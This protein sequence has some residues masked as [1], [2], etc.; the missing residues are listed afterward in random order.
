MLKQLKYK[1]PG[2]TTHATGSRSCTEPGPAL[3]VDPTHSDTGG[4]STPV[5]GDRRDHLSREESQICLCTLEN[6]LVIL[7]DPC[8]RIPKIRELKIIIPQTLTYVCS[9]ESERTDI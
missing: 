4:V 9:F 5:P 2:T 7:E 3:S 8:L 6:T 1:V